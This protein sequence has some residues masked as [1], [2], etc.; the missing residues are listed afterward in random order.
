VDER[1]RISELVQQ[2]HVSRSTVNRWLQHGLPHSKVGR[3]ILLDPR[4]VEAWVRA[5]SSPMSQLTAAP[6]IGRIE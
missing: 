6:R 1:I 5:G 4:E 2:L 3:I